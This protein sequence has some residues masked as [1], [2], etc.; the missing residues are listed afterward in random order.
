MTTHMSMQMDNKGHWF[1]RNVEHHSQ[2]MWHFECKNLIFS[3]NFRISFW[4][5]QKTL[6][7]SLM[8]T[9][10]DG[11]WFYRNVKHCGWPIVKMQTD[12]ICLFIG[13]LHFECNNAISFSHFGLSFW[14]AKKTLIC[15]CVQMEN[16][17]CQF[18][19]NVE[20]H[21][22][23]NVDMQTQVDEVC[24]FVSPSWFE[25]NDSISLLHFGFSF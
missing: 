10:N 22:W 9:E 24:S 16:K 1:K 5:A 12:E 18:K 4:C 17:K 6:I 20:H 25:C 19:R 8:Q 11:H 21:T 2:P 3:W 13:A 14:N 23:L 15:M 7:F